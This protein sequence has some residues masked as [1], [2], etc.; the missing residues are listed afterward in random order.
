M[1]G[2]RTA[3]YGGNTTCVEVRVAGQVLVLDA[4]TG[5]IALGQELLANGL[6]PS[7]VLLFTHF[8]HDHFIGLP[9]FA[10]LY[11]PGATCHFFG[12]NMPEGQFHEAISRVVA[13]PYFP[14]CLD[15]LPSTRTFHSLDDEGLLCWRPGA[16]APE[17]VDP[18]SVSLSD[19]V[20]QVR[21]FRSQAHPRDGVVIYRIAWRGRSVVFATDVEGEPDDGVLARFTHKAD[22]LIHDAQ[23]SET[24]YRGPAPKRGFGHSTPRMATQVAADAQVGELLIFHH[25][26][27]YDDADVQAMETEACRVFPRS[28]AAFEG[29]TI[30]L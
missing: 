18:R 25:D 10:P 9:F 12:P 3:R 16:A 19:E 17:C 11:H 8:H 14:L 6:P 7:L 22:L 30:R 5:I 13:P 1:P 29:L 4:G 2:P 26:P 15:D 20:V 21:Y 27:T 28:R 24:D 23:Y